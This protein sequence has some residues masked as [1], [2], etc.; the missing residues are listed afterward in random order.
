MKSKQVNEI[1]TCLEFLRNQ[2]LDLG[3]DLSEGFKFGLVES[4]SLLCRKK[5]SILLVIFTNVQEVTSTELRDSCK[6]LASQRNSLKVR[7]GKYA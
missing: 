2:F 4:D 3:E 6:A 7:T 5:L 1:R